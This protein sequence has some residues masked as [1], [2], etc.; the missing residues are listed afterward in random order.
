MCEKNFLVEKLPALV[1]FNEDT[2]NDYFVMMKKSYNLPLNKKELF[3]S[4]NIKYESKFKK[5]KETNMD[6]FK[7]IV[8][9]TKNNKQHILIFFEDDKVFIILYMKI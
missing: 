9:E 4:F 1:S 8:A 3:K 5:L 6:E 2:E 7:Q